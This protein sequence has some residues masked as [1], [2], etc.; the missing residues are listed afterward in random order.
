[1]TEV[2]VLQSKLDLE[3]LGFGG[4]MILWFSK[5]KC[6]EWFCL[7]CKRYK[8]KLR[9]TQIASFSGF[10]GC[11]FPERKTRCIVV[12]RSKLG[13]NGTTW[14]CLLQSN[15]LANKELSKKIFSITF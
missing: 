14:H 1:M 9:I 12:Y 5:I 6:Q 2:F 13:R 15:L 3:S 8:E 10:L 4:E 11:G 7:L